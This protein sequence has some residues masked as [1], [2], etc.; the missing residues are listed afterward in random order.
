MNYLPV[1][2]TII[3]L[4]FLLLVFVIRAAIQKKITEHHAIL[5]LI[6][7]IIIIIGGCFPQLTYTLSAFFN[8][9]YPP[10]IIFAVAIIL[11]YIILFQCFKLLS[12]LL[13]KNKELASNTA[14]LEKQVEEL[15][16]ELQQI[17]SVQKPEQENRQNP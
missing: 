4:G 13:M 1:Q 16:K 14:I 12:V 5:W 9:E 7:C 3:I 11:L 6:P 10:A 15:K 8:T 2:I 17:K